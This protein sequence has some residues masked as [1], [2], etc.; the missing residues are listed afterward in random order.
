MSTMVFDKPDDPANKRLQPPLWH[1]VYNESTVWFWRM[2]SKE[3]VKHTFAKPAVRYGLIG[4]ALAA[5][6]AALFVSVGR[7]SVSNWVDQKLADVTR[8]AGAD[9]TAPRPDFGALQIVL[10]NAVINPSASAT[11]VAAFNEA[12]IEQLR[13]VAVEL[14]SGKKLD[15]AGEMKLTGALQWDKLVMYRKVDDKTVVLGMA[16]KNTQPAG[17]AHADGTPVEIRL[18]DTMWMGIA[19]IEGGK[20]TV[21]N[22]DL[23]SMAH[24]SAFIP[25]VAPAM[26]PRLLSTA[27]GDDAVAQ[28]NYEGSAK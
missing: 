18:P 24:K 8:P 12:A 9:L 22:L 1:K 19:R 15:Y 13:G 3:L 20:A 25:S 7:T 10:R 27:F 6:A 28:V 2:N 11:P 17:Y 23:G 5:A 4:V 16:L 14:A 26:V 21:Y